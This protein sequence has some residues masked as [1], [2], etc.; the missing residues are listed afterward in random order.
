M[1]ALGFMH[2][3]P[4]ILC[5]AKILVEPTPAQADCHL[6]KEQSIVGHFQSYYLLH[7]KITHQK[8]N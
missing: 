6:L 7:L 2:C 1:C 3:F 5:A 8:G 4:Y